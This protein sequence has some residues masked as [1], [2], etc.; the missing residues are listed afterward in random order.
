[1]AKSSSPPKKSKGTVARDSAAEVVAPAVTKSQPPL[2]RKEETK[3]MTEVGSIIEFSED[4]ANAEAP[5]PLPI[6]D[7]PATIR[8]AEAK[9]SSKGKPMLEVQFFVASESYPADF[10]EGD[11]DGLVLTHYVSIDDSQR[12]RYRMRKFLEAIGAKLGSRLDVNELLGLTAT[13]S[14]VHDTYEGET[15]AKIG[16][17][18][19]A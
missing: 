7:Y 9:I 5:A 15:R 11:P 16:K 13:L 17:V 8:S 10:T 19:E 1:M 18:Q 12:G 2:Q 6:G 3:T 4:L 14:V